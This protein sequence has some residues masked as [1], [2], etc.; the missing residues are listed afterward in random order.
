MNSQNSI[1][2]QCEHLQ[3]KGSKTNPEF[4]DIWHTSD[5]LKAPFSSRA[6]WYVFMT[7]RARRS[8]SSIVGSIIIPGSR[9]WNTRQ[10]RLMRRI[11]IQPVRMLQ[12]TEHT[13]PTWHRWCRSKSAGRERAQSRST[14]VV[15]P[16]W[17][18]G[19]TH[20]HVDRVVLSRVR[21]NDTEILWG[22]W[23]SP[24]PAVVVTMPINPMT[25][26]EPWKLDHP[27]QVKSI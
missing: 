23:L 5:D 12:I 11:S 8:T 18:E 27:H 7:V 4:S 9:N 10:L 22:D 19:I 21:W 17:P 24:V 14:P 26:V 3:K 1:P 16:I 13:R 25:M 20:A 15:W 2:E 6:F